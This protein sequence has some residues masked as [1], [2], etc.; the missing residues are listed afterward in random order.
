MVWGTARVSVGTCVVQCT[1]IL[2]RNRVK[3]AVL[4]YSSQ[5]IRKTVDNYIKTYEAAGAT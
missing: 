4:I 1:H 5:L 2:H 3:S